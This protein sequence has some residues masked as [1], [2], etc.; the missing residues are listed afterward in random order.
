V[1]IAKFAVDTA[2]AILKTVGAVQ[3]TRKKTDRA[4]ASA[5]MPDAEAARQNKSYP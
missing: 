4:P 1:S 5:G 3:L 2:V